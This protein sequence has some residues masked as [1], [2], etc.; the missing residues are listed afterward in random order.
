MARDGPSNQEGRGEGNRAPRSL[1]RASD[2]PYV[3]AHRIRRYP[4]ADHTPNFSPWGY[5]RP[6]SMRRVGNPGPEEKRSA[7]PRDP[8]RHDGPLGCQPTCDEA[9]PIDVQPDDASHHRAMCAIFHF[10]VTTPSTGSIA[11][12]HQFP[13]APPHWLATGQKRTNLTG[14]MEDLDRDDL[15]DRASTPG[16][17]TVAAGPADAPRQRLRYL[18]AACR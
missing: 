9:E 16:Q 2:R 6:L 8:L 10:G 5:K 1:R 18:A 13:H 15:N 12:L 7:V 11:R 3:S 14:F 17:R 4:A